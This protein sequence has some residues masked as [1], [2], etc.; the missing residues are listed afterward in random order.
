M[1]LK[2]KTTVRVPVEDLNRI[3]EAYHAIGRFLEHYIEPGILYKDEFVKGMET[4]LNE[5]SRK[6][7][8][9]VKTFN[10]FVS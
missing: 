8:K 6:E 7:T 3:L 2:T 4:A 5:V 10:H 1:A 9:L